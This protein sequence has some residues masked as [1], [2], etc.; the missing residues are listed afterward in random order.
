MNRAALE[1]VDCEVAFDNLTR[2]LYATDASIY[3]IEPA[4]VAFPRNATQ[5]AAVIRAAA[6]QDLPL[7]PR[8]AGTG[9]AGGAI[10]DGLVVEFARFNREISKLDRERRTVRVGAG[11]VLDQ[12]NE[13]LK[14]AGFCFG[15]DVATSSRATLGGM[16]ANNSSGAHV[17]VYGVTADHVQSLEVV[18]AD[19]RIQTLRKGG[20]SS[21]EKLVAGAAGE[22][23][24]RMPDGLLKRWPGYG[25]DRFLREPNASHL[26]AGSEGTLA[27]ILSAELKIVPL[28]RRKSLGLIFFASVAEAMQATVELLPLKP[29]AIEHVDRALFEQTRGQLNFKA[30]RDLL[31]LDAKPC[32]AILIVEFFDDAGD[33][34]AALGGKWLGLRNLLLQDPASMNL[35]WHMRKAGLSLL[36]SCKGNAKPVPG[37][38]DTAV[39]PQQL[40]EYVAA[41][42]SIF[43]RRQL[44]ASFYGHAAAGLLHVRPV[45]D[46]HEA[47]DV[48]KFRELADEV[49]ALVR[50]F[51]GS[52]SAEHGVGIARTEFVP[53]QLG[54]GLL[55]LM[56]EIKNVFDPRGLFNPGKLLPDGRFKFDTNL[57][58]GGGY[59]LP[60]PFSPV[61]AF[62]ARD[63]SFT[64]NLEQCNGCGGCRKETPTMCPTFL[65]T[66]EEIMSTR[67]RANAIRAALECR[68]TKDA[69]CS[70]EIEMAL[71]NCLSCKACMVECPSNVNLTLLKAELLHARHGR[72]GLSWRERLFSSVDLLGRLGCLAPSLANRLLQSAALRRWAHSLLD[73]S[74]RR[75]LPP[76][77]PERFDHWFA[78][79][80]APAGGGRGRVF[81]WDDTFARYHEPR[82]ARAAVEV[83]EA[84][85]FSTALVAS[86]KCCGRPAFSQGR[87]DKAAALGRHNLQLLTTGGGNEPVLF[88]EPSCYS[89]F[90]EDYLELKLPGAAEVKARCFLFEEFVENLLAREPGALAFKAAPEK[91]AIHA[92]CHA[93]S[94]LNVGFMKRVIERMPGR[95]AALLE[96]GCC[97]MAG[98]F[99]ALADKYELS[100]T[101]AQPLLAQ[102][103]AQPAGT[104]VVAS[105][106]SCRH[107]LE[108]LSECHPRH[109]AEVLAA[110]LKG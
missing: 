13:F 32:E 88:L 41:L 64:A 77:A 47:G 58:L 49:A 35:V 73:I 108:H 100:V 2:Q 79:R 95:S 30:A 99:G 16:I 56:R 68:G 107:Q 7:I 74:E 5:A 19:G 69:L 53:E 12:L 110:G 101:V 89:M 105:G 67:G 39:R 15:P 102:I 106:T 59:E 9:L 34:L 81:L 42:Q 57:R 50:Q 54:P 31:Q 28:P 94:L 51:K 18:L 20:N 26:L 104:I 93:K 76:Y 75:P 24:E 21:L 86:R 66:G 22:I 63:G 17:P 97:G 70:A 62:A 29:A 36:T 90:A 10:G 11:V 40:P 83:L 4:A 8:G 96:T 98:A 109:I 72:H 78:R 80:T 91:I 55:R 46:L 60:L 52:L 3:Q 14:P 48:K 44:K 33:R 25:V 84:A 87:L 85:G 92:H 61:L 38:E 82:I 23:R 43:D 65:A 103:Q 71:D 27:A 37:V 1:K 45:L 6:D